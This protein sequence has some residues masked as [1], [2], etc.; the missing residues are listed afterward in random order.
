MSASGQNLNALINQAMNESYYEFI[1]HA[2]NFNIKYDD[3]EDMIQNAFIVILRKKDELS[4]KSINHLRKYIK[5]QITWSCLNRKKRKGHLKFAYL[6]IDQCQDLFE[7]LD[8]S[9]ESDCILYLN[10][11]IEDCNEIQKSV[12]KLKFIDRMKSKHVGEI[13]GLK[14]DAVDSYVFRIKHQIRKKLANEYQ[15]Q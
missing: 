8:Q 5:Q 6:Q 15:T 11:L 1:K 9:D 4:F 2:L 14:K 13:L 7:S 12:A 10:Q 3:A